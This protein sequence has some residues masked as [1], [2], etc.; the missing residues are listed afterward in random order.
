MNG[1]SDQGMVFIHTAQRALLPHLEWAVGRILGG[2]INIQW[3]PVSSSQ[4]RTEFHWSGDSMTATDLASELMGW[5]S[6]RF[7]V[8]SASHRWSF[9]PKLG[10]FHSDTDAAGNLLIS[11]FRLKSALENAGSN[12]LEMQRQMRELIGQPWDD[13]LEQFR[14]HGT[15][16]PVVWLQSVAN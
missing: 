1:I 16:A 12:A 13:E 14:A 15:D 9:T 6:I 2:P 3:R 10:L 5:K 7:E 8:T 4:F 11:E